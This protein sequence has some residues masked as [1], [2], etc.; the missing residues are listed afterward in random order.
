MLVD[1]SMYLSLWDFG[2][3]VKSRRLSGK[4]LLGTLGPEQF[5]S[6]IGQVGESLPDRYLRALHEQRLHVAQGG[7]AQA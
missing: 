6:V 3:V 4:S 7:H 5:I 2:P 1:S